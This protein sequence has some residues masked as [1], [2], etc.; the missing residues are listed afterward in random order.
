MLVPR[1]L[2]VTVAVPFLAVPAAA[3]ADADVAARLKLDGA[4]AKQVRVAAVRPATGRATISLP[5][6]RVRAG[7]LQT[8]IAHR[9]SLRFSAGARKL[10][11]TGVTTT[12]GETATV[13]GRLAG[14]TVTLLELKLSAARRQALA[15]ANTIVLDRVRADLT[16]AAARLLRTRLKLPTLRPGALARVTLNV[17]GSETTVVPAP[18][19][20]AP[21]AA[22]TRKIVGG[23]A[24]WGVNVGL[25]ELFP[26]GQVNYNHPDEPMRALTDGATQLPDDAFGFTVVG[27]WYDPASGR[28]QVA[29]QG[30]VRFGYYI[31]GWTKYPPADGIAHGIW[32]SFAALTASLQPSGGTL[33]GLTDAGFHDRAWIR[34]QRRA[35]ADLGAT[36]PSTSGSTVT[37]TAIPATLN[38]VGGPL[39]HGYFPA[40]SPLDPLTITAQLDG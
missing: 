32:T 3:Q 5:V 34:P 18:A 13:R 31:G 2:I 17:I 15:G 24:S 7:R 26:Q 38:A 23:S 35:F 12:L 39:G 29:L 33:E 36:A 6:A 9:G 22:T 16:P 20:A 30:G 4:A 1:S 14:R 11:A 21:P 25:R 10:T 8:K 37:W 27:G 19:G 40:G 28:A